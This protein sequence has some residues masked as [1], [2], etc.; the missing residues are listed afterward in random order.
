MQQSETLHAQL[1]AEQAT[2]ARY[3]AIAQRL[4]EAN[5]AADKRVAR[6][7]RELSDTS[8]VRALVFPY[9]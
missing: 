7:E 5:E 3:E 1:A 8:Q 6:L 2:A 9:M 4:A